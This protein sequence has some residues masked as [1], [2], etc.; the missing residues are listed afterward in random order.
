M[1]IDK[2]GV[3]VPIQDVTGSLAAFEKLKNQIAQDNNLKRCVC[4][5]LLAK[6][7]KDSKMLNIKRKNLDLIAE[8][9]EVKIK[10]PSCHQ[11]T[12]L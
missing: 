11:V 10:C 7:D 4:G 1:A 12:S 6:L 3:A 2:K 8:V 5:Q 9:S